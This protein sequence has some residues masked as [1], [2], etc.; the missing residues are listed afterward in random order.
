MRAQ[1]EVG[2]AAPEFA[3][4]NS[5]GEKVR[6]SDFAGQYVVVMFYK[7]DFSPV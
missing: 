7:L 3:L 1:P 4:L 2:Q 5:R 6:M